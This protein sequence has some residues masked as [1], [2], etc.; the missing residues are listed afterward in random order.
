MVPRGARNELA[1]QLTAAKPRSMNVLQ[2]VG[3]S[4]VSEDSQVTPRHIHTHT[5]TYTHVVSAFQEPTTYPLALPAKQQ[6]WGRGGGH[7]HWEGEGSQVGCSDYQGTKCSTPLW[8]K[9]IQEIHFLFLFLIFLLAIA[10]PQ[11]LRGEALLNHFFLSYV[12]ALST[13]PAC[14]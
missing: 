2:Q 8:R 7:G 11:T 5:H 9:I 4:C 1:I 14:M 6:G 3:P 13:L 12:S 10:R